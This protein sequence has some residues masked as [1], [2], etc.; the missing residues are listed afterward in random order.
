MCPRA[1]LQA[2]ISMGEIPAAF[3]VEKYFR[4][5]SSEDCFDGTEKQF[6]SLHRRVKLLLSWLDLEVLSVATCTIG[7]MYH[8]QGPVV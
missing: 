6:L 8:K 1:M 5:M 2:E 7:N 3:L 4:L